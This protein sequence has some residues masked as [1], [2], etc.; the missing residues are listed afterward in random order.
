[1]HPGPIRRVHFV[2]YNANV[3]TLQL[4]QMFPKY[5]TALLAAL[6]RQRGYEVRVFLEGTSDMA[7]EKM[8]DCDAVCFPVFAPA[9]NK[10]RACAR[11]FR[12]ERPRLPIIMGGPHVCMHTETI[13]DVC[14]CA[15]R[16]EGDEVLP[17]ILDCMSN[18]G[19]WR[20]LQGVSYMEAGRVIHNPDRT[21]PAIPDIGPDF[22]LI[23]GF[24]RIRGWPTARRV[25]NTLQTS[26]GCH[27]KCKFCPT[28][29]LFGGSYRTRSIEGIIQDIRARRSY[30]PIFFVVDN[31]FLGDRRR[32]TELLHR[33]AREQLGAY[34][35]VFERHDIGMDEEMLDL[36]RRAGVRCIIVGIE[37]L[38]DVNLESYHK[39]QSSAQVIK[40]VETIQRHDLHVIG[41][42][43]LGGDNDTPATSDRV[44]QFVKDTGVSLNLFIV[45]DLEDD[46][47]KGLFIPLNRRFQTYY[48]RTDPHST[49]FFDYLSGS[50]VTYF[51]KRMKP[52]T[53]QQCVLD[54]YDRVYT[55]GR[56]LQRVCSKNIFVSVFGVAHGYGIKRMN[57]SLRAIVD[58]GYM[59]HLRRLEDGLYDA[60]ENLIEERLAEL[61]TLPIPGPVLPSPQAPRYDRLIPIVAFPGIARYGLA[62]LRH[63]ARQAMGRLSPA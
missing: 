49:D 13:L 33:L 20:S 25:V 40:A 60:Q 30:S 38:D 3:G 31:S 41:T 62:I 16:C 12:D 51:P 2:E 23:E 22:T 34:L 32:A 15:V 47:S 5:G 46:E 59:D 19:D 4:F 8:L 21:P 54:T 37:S 48:R 43:V 42:F 18:G 17:Q 7:F 6:L 63:R 61:N 53:L 45:H 44:V 14:D 58:R 57:K 26:R 29:K 35:I 24:D 56:I 1:M 52:S 10:V 50:F 36:M 11:R 27:F 55:H 28:S 9:L 39:R